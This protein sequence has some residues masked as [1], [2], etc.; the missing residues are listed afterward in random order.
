M[1]L[2]LDELKRNGV[3]LDMN[4]GTLSLHIN[5]LLENYNST[6]QG[7]VL[8]SINLTIGSP[9]T[10]CDLNLNAWYTRLPHNNNVD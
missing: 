5:Y 8:K 2:I 6:F 3:D 10:L 7:I 1:E 9:D 4:M